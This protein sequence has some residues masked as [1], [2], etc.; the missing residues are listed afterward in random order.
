VAEQ[1]YSVTFGAEAGKTY[2]VSVEG[3]AAAPSMTY[4]LTVLCNPP[5]NEDVCDD[6]VDN[7]GDLVADCNDGDCSAACADPCTAL[8]HL[9][10]NATLS[11]GDTATGSNLHDS[12]GCY[13][14]IAL[15]GN[16]FIYSFTAPAAGRYLFTLSNETDYGTI[17]VLTNDGSG[18]NTN[19]CLAFQYYSVAADLVPDQIYYIAVDAPNAGSM[20]YDLSVIQNPPSSE[21]GLCADSIDN[22]G[23][24]NIDCYDPECGCT[25]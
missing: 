8:Y 3:D 16:E 13:P 18:C 25:P 19:S 22:D 11:I 6:G 24:F 4:D 2:Y 1:Y 20:T 5:A 14:G 12:Y 17:A 23:D 9:D 10:S 15:P 7:D 21:A